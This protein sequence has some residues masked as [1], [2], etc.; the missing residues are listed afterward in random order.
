MYKMRPLPTAVDQSFLDRLARLET[1]TIGH[2]HQF[3]FA[4]PSLQSVI[5]G[6]TAVGTAVTLALPGQDSTLLHHVIAQLR[7][8]DFLVIDRLGDM[9]H[10]CFGGGVAL[11]SK[12]QGFAGAAVDG[13]HTDTSEIAEHGFALWSRGASPI[14]TRLY[15]IGGGFNIP[16][17]CAG[18]AVLP[19]YAVLADESG[20]LFIAPDDL[21]EV[22]S[23]AE[24]KTERGLATTQRQRSGE[25][26]GVI[27]GA[28]E[29]VETRLAAAGG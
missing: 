18:A 12:Q 6:T 10:A 23:T 28:T 20:V 17:C 14:T 8:G 19:G 26:L 3:G 15:D 22:I 7:P 11:A 16:V 1:A 21:E 29:K 2:T 27:S 25:K 4:D 13:V 24:V 5:P 9:R